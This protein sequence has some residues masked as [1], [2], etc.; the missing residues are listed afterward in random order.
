MKFTALKV[1]YYLNIDESIAPT[2]Q[3]SIS[4]GEDNVS[5]DVSNLTVVDGLNVT[6]VNVAAAQMTENIVVSVVN[7]EENVISNTYTIRGYCDTILS[8]EAYSAYH[9]LI[10]E[11]LAYGGATQTYFG[12]NIDDLASNGITDTGATAIPKTADA[13]MVVSGSADGAF[14]YGASLLYRNK[15]AVRFY[16]SGDVTG[17]TFTVNGKTYEAVAKGDLCYVEIADI[18]PQN[19]DQ[20]ITV[21]VTDGINTLTVSYGPMNYIVRMNAKGSEN[22]QALLT[23]IYN[24]H[25]AAKALHTR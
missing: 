20:Q 4:V 12:Y 25:L 18:L 15:I 9:A 14:F 6:S 10:K 13:E 5:C 3:V 22:L 2:A 1:N 7:G 21:A 23:A 11:M 8:D 24:Y 19:L 16:F 17:L